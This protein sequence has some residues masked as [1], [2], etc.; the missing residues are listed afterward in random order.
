MEL[1]D[2][3]QK[4]NLLWQENFDSPEEG[5]DKKPLQQL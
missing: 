1:Q 2:K 3:I 5:V 4:N